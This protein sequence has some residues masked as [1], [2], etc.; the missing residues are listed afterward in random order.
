[1]IKAE[2]LE[3][4]TIISALENG[5]FYAS[6][7]PEITELYLEENILHV[8]CSGVATIAL[9]TDRRRNQQKNAAPGELLTTAEF[10]LTKWFTDES[11]EG[12][13][14]PYFRIAVKDARGNMAYTR[15]YFLDEVK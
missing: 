2:K 10:D 12:A 9:A 15:A 8:A 4:G 1:M 13:A 6:T 3:Y 11:C 5:D 14:D 7:G